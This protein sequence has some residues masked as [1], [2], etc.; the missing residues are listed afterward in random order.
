MIRMEPRSKRQETE[1]LGELLGKNFDGADIAMTVTYDPKRTQRT[2]WLKTLP[3]YFRA[4]KDGLKNFEVRK[5][6]RDF[7]TGDILVLQEYLP[8]Q[9][10]RTGYEI[11]KRVKYLLRDPEYCKEGYVVMSLEDVR[12]PERATYWEKKKFVEGPL[13]ELCRAAAG[14]VVKLDYIA[15]DRNGYTDERVTVRI[16]GGY[17]LYINVSENSLLAIAAEVLRAIC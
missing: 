11:V 14:Q 16:G 2:H 7:E 5:D 9:D 4:M 10:T 1:K 6:D 15:V 13:Q 8:E 3:L 12:P 17:P